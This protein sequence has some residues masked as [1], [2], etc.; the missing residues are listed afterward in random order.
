MAKEDYS[1]FNPTT[2]EAAQAAFQGY[3]P[4]DVSQYQEAAANTQGRT[5][6]TDGTSALEA[7]YMQGYTDA[8][9]QGQY[10]GDKDA[11]LDQGV[12]G[13]SLDILGNAV[14]S[15]GGMVIDAGGFIGSALSGMPEISQ[16]ANK[17][18]E[19]LHELLQSNAAN[20]RKRA[21]AARAISD[22]LY[23]EQLYRKD[24]ANGMDDF[25][26]TLKKV[27]RDAVYWGE[28][29]SSSDLQLFAGSALGSLGGSGIVAKGILKG[30]SKLLGA[31]ASRGKLAQAMAI[32]TPEVGGTY[33]DAASQVM[34]MS[35][36][37]LYNKS[38]E[39]VGIVKE[40]LAKGYDQRTAELMARRDLAN[41]AARSAAVLHTPVAIAAGSLANIG[42]RPAA[43]MFDKAT[44]IAPKSVGSI[45]KSI[46]PAG[47]LGETTEETLQG[48]SSTLAT[49][50]AI[51]N[52]A[53]NTK[54]YTD[55]LGES[56]AESAYGGAISKG[57]ASGVGTINTT[58]QVIKN[59][60][61][62]EE[63]SNTENTTTSNKL[64]DLS[65]VANTT[66]S[67]NTNSTATVTNVDSA[68]N[69]NTTSENIKQEPINQVTQE[70]L[71]KKIN[72]E[73][74][75][76]KEEEHTKDM[77]T[78]PIDGEE[79]SE[80]DISPLDELSNNQNV[81]ST[82]E[83]I[84][85]YLHEINKDDES[86]THYYDAKK[87]FT[88]FNSDE[89][90]PRLVEWKNTKEEIESLQNSNEDK[91]EEIKA[92]TEK[93]NKL[94]SEINNIVNN[95]FNN[96]EAND[97]FATNE[98]LASF[99]MQYPDI[100]KAPKEKREE[101]RNLVKK[102]N[103]QYGKYM[104]NTISN[105]QTD[106]EAVKV[107]RNASD[108]E[109]S[110]YM[111]SMYNIMSSSNTT[112]AQKEAAQTRLQKIIADP[113]AREKFR[114]QLKTEVYKNISAA[115]DIQD[116][117]KKLKA[118]SDS[119]IFA[120]TSTKILLENKSDKA[121]SKGGSGK[122]RY[123]LTA[124]SGRVISS[125]VRGNKKSLEKNLN[126]LLKVVD[127]KIQKHVALENALRNADPNDQLFRSVEP[128]T[129]EESV[130]SV[131]LGNSGILDAN[132]KE[133]LAMIK[134]YN[135]IIDVLS[136][137]GL[138]KFGENDEPRKKITYRP[139][140]FD[141]E[142]INRQMLKIKLARKQRNSD[143][144]LDK[145]DTPLLNENYEVV[146]IMSDKFAGKDNDDVELVATRTDNLN[147]FLNQA[148]EISENEEK[149]I[150][151]K[152]E[153]NKLNKLTEDKPN[154]DIGQIVTDSTKDTLEKI[155]G[156]KKTEP[157]ETPVNLNEETN[158][159]EEDNSNI[160]LGSNNESTKETNLKFD[161]STGDRYTNAGNYGTI[162]YIDSP[163]LDE[164]N[165]PKLDEKGEQ[166][167]FKQKVQLES[168]QELVEHNAK[169]KEEIIKD[170]PNLS[171]ND[172]ESLNAL[173]SIANEQDT[174]LENLHFVAYD[175]KPESNVSDISTYKLLKNYK[176]LTG[177]KTDKD[178]IATENALVKKTK[179]SR[180][181]NDF[182]AIRF[183]NKDTKPSSD[184]ISV[185]ENYNKKDGKK[186][187]NANL[188]S[189]TKVHPE[190]TNYIATTRAKLLGDN[191]LG[192]VFSQRT[193]DTAIEKAINMVFV[194]RGT[195]ESTVKN[196]NGE[197]QTV[198]VKTYQKANVILIN[199]SLKKEDKYALEQL[200]HYTGFK[201]M[202]V[203]KAMVNNLQEGNLSLQEAYDDSFGSANGFY[204]NNSIIP[205]T[206]TEE[207]DLDSFN[208]SLEEQGAKP[209]DN[210]LLLIN[211]DNEPIKTPTSKSISL[212]KLKTKITK[213]TPNAFN[214]LIFPIRNLL[215]R[216]RWDSGI[217]NE[218]EF[219]NKCME[220]FSNDQSLKTLYNKFREAIENNWFNN[221]IKKSIEENKGVGR[222]LNSLFNPETGKLDSSKWSYSNS[223]LVTLLEQN[224]KAEY[225]VNP[226][227]AEALVS[228]ATIVTAEFAL[229]SYNKSDEA[230][231]ED[232]KNR[233]ITEKEF[234]K[235]PEE[236]REALRNGVTTELFI[237]A[238]ASKTKD[239]LGI[240]TNKNVS[241]TNNA[242]DSFKALAF[243]G[244]EFAKENGLLNLTKIKLDE[245][246]D[247]SQ[248]SINWRPNE[249]TK[250]DYISKLTSS[251]EERNIDKRR[252][253]FADE[254][255]PPIPKYKDN[256]IEMS[257]M[258]IDNAK[259]T[260]GVKYHLDEEAYDIFHDL[261]PDG[262]AAFF[263]H[264]FADNDE[265]AKFKAEYT[266][267]SDSFASNSGKSKG[268]ARDLQYLEER[269]E[270]LHNRF[271]NEPD[272]HY[273]RTDMHY[274]ANGRTQEYMPNG[275]QGSK[276]HR[277][278]FS[279]V[280]SELDITNPEDMYTFQKS[281]IQGLG[282]KPAKMSKDV[283][284]SSF[285]KLLSVIKNVELRKLPNETAFEFG[286][287]MYQVLLDMNALVPQVDIS[288]FGRT[289]LALQ[290]MI[291]LKRYQQALENGNKNIKITLPLERDG[292]SD[293]THNGQILLSPLNTAKDFQQLGK[294]GTYIGDENQ[295]K[296]DF[297]K[298]KDNADN[299]ETIARQSSEESK[300]VYNDNIKPTL[301]NKTLDI[302]KEKFF[303]N[304]VR[305]NTEKRF[306]EKLTWNDIA[307]S[308]YLKNTAGT[309]VVEAIN[310]M[311]DLVGNLDTA[312]KLF[313]DGFSITS[314]S[315]SKVNDN[316]EE[317]NNRVSEYGE[318]VDAIINADSDTKN[319]LDTL[320]KTVEE[321]LKNVDKLEKADKP[322][323][324][325]IATAK[326]TASK[327][328]KEL[329]DFTEKT[330]NS[331][332]QDILQEDINF[333]LNGVARIHA[334]LPATASVYGQ[335]MAANS[336]NIVDELQ[337]ER[338]AKKIDNALEKISEKFTNSA[339]EQVIKEVRET[340]DWE[341]ARSKLK[342]TPELQ[343]ELH[344]AL[345]EL[346]VSCID[347]LVFGKDYKKYRAALN[348]VYL[349]GS[350]G[351]NGKDF[352]RYPLGVTQEYLELTPIFD[353][354]NSDIKLKN[355]WG[356]AI[357]NNLDRNQ[358][359]YD[360]S[361]GNYIEVSQEVK[362][363][364]IKGQIEKQNKAIQEAF[365]SKRF[366]NASILDLINF[367]RNYD[368]RETLSGHGKTGYSK[369]SV[370]GITNGIG[371]L[372]GEP[373][374][375]ATQ[376][377]SRNN[378]Q[379][380][381][382][383]LTATYVV[384]GLIHKYAKEKGVTDYSRL[385][386]TGM[387]Q[388]EE[389]ELDNKI[390]T[391]YGVRDT[392]VSTHAETGLFAKTR[393]TTRNGGFGKISNDDD[394]KNIEN[395][396][397][398]TNPLGGTGSTY[399]LTSTYN[400]NA[401]GVQ[402]LSIIQNGDA[403]MQNVI[404]QLAVSNEGLENI[405]EESRNTIRELLKITRNGFDGFDNDIAQ[406]QLISAILNFT[407]LAK[408]H[409][410]SMTESMLS[411]L[412]SLLNNDSGMNLLEE[413]YKSN[414][415]FRYDLLRT[416]STVSIEDNVLIG[417]A[418]EDGSS[419]YKALATPPSFTEL[420][421]AL[422]KMRD[423]V[424]QVNEDIKKR[425]A[426]LLSYPIN[427]SHVSIDEYGYAYNPKEY[428]EANDA[429]KS[430]LT[431][432]LSD[433]DNTADYNV[434]AQELSDDFNLRASCT[435]A[436]GD[437]TYK[438]N[439]ELYLELKL[440]KYG[441]QEVFDP[442]NKDAT[443][444]EKD[445]PKIK[446]LCD[447]LVNAG[448]PERQYL[449]FISNLVDSGILKSLIKGATIGS[450][451]QFFSSLFEKDMRD[452][453]N[454]SFRKFFITDKI[455]APQYLNYK[456]L[457]SEDI[458]NDVKNGAFSWANLLTDK[459]K[460]YISSKYPELSDKCNEIRALL[461]S[462]NSNT[463][464]DSQISTRE[465]HDG[466]IVPSLKLA[467]VIASDPELLNMARDS[468]LR[469]L[470]DIMSKLQSDS[471]SG[472]NNF[473]SAQRKIDYSKAKENDV[474]LSNEVGNATTVE[475][476][477]PKTSSE[478][479]PPVHPFDF[480][481]SLP[482]KNNRT[483]K[484]NL[485]DFKNTPIWNHL[486]VSAT[487]LQRQILNSHLPS[488]LEVVI[489]GT[490]PKDNN[491]FYYDANNEKIVISA[492]AL[493]D[494]I[495]SFISNPE[496]LA[497][498]T[499]I[500][501]HELM[502]A[503]T[504]KLIL[505]AKQAKDKGL[506]TPVTKALDAIND[507]ANN[508]AIDLNS[509]ESIDALLNEIN[510]NK[511]LTA[512]DKKLL[513]ENIKYFV[514][515][516]KT[517]RNK[518]NNGLDG[519]EELVELVA[520]VL[521]N[522][523][524][525]ELL[526]TIEVKVSSSTLDT[527]REYWKQLAQNL[528]DFLALFCSRSFK[529][530]VKTTN[531][532]T[533][534][535][536]MSNSD[537]NKVNL[538]V[539]LS[540]ASHNLISMQEM[541]QEI[542]NS[543]ISSYRLGVDVKSHSNEMKVGDLMQRL[544]DLAKKNP[545]FYYEDKIS[546]SSAGSL[547]HMSELR[548]NN[549]QQDEIK[550][551][552]MQLN[553][554]EDTKSANITSLLTKAYKYPYISNAVV[555][556]K[557]QNLVTSIFKYLT[558]D[559]L[560][561]TDEKEKLSKKEVNLLK[562]SR[563]NFLTNLGSYQVST[564]MALVYT[565]PKFSEMLNSIN[566]DKV[567][568]HIKGLNEVKFSENELDNTIANFTANAL[569]R[570]SDIFSGSAK[571][572]NIG[573]LANSLTNE[574]IREKVDYE[575]LSIPNKLITKTEEGFKS[576]LRK[577]PDAKP[578]RELFNFLSK[579]KNRLAR[580]I[581]AIAKS[582]RSYEA[583]RDNLVEI[584]AKDIPLL[585]SLVNFIVKEL[586]AADKNMANLHALEKQ[587]KAHI[588]GMRTAYRETTPQL[589]KKDFQKAGVTYTPEIGT[590]LTKGV[591][592]LD[593][594]C[595]NNNQIVSTL[596][597]SQKELS[598][599]KLTDVP[600]LNKFKNSFTVANKKNPE[601]LD[602][603]RTNHWNQI[604]SFADDLAYKLATGSF[605]NTSG[606]HFRSAQAILNYFGP[607]RDGKHLE[608]P[609]SLVQGL[610][611][612][613]SIKALSYLEPDTY[614]KLSDLNKTSKKKGAYINPVLYIA[615]AQ[616]DLRNQE[617]TNCKHPLNQIKGYYPK[618]PAN[619]AHTALVSAKEYNNYLALGYIDTGKSYT[620][621]KGKKFH[622]MTNTRNPIGSY[623]Q[624]ALQTVLNKSGGV[625]SYT[626][627][628]HEKVAEYVSKGD[629]N[630]KPKFFVPVNIDSAK[631][632]GNIVFIYN[633][634]TGNPRGYEILSDDSL[635]ENMQYETDA[636]QIIGDWRGRNHE[637]LAAMEMNKAVLE[638]L[639]E[640]YLK[641]RSNST[642][643]N[644]YIN[645]LESK[646]AVIKDALEAFPPEIH[647]MLKDEKL[648]PDGF[649]IRKDL[650]EDVIGYREAS[651]NDLLVGRTDFIN[652]DR[653]KAITSYIIKLVGPSGFSKI[654]KAEDILKSTV[655]L[656]KNTIVL[657]SGVVMVANILANTM[658][659]SM[660]GVP[661]NTMVPDTINITKQL[662]HYNV[663]KKRRIALE[664][665]LSKTD[666][667][668]LTKV[669]QIKKSI[670]A[671]D[672]ALEQAIPDIK[673]LIDAGEY[674]TISDLSD[675]NDDV[676]PK[677]GKFGEWLDEQWKKLP[678]PVRNAGRYA[679]VSQGTA[680]YRF[681]E[682]GTQY[683]DFIGKAIYYKHLIDEMGLTKEEALE[684]VR[685]VFVN[686]DMLAG[687]GRAYL[688]N[689]GLLWFFN[690]KLRIVRSAWTMLVDHPLRFALS[691]VLPF[692]FDLD[693]PL[694][695]NVLSKAL[696]GSL[697]SS[698]GVDTLL[699][700]PSQN[701]WL[702]LTA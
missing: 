694:T 591:L 419:D 697:S 625:D 69:T 574:L 411:V 5:Y 613:I 685:Y 71:D 658:Q 291:H 95:D 81:V 640:M 272:K 151:Q 54:G 362:D 391:E 209:D 4:K 575:K 306:L 555:K 378:I 149:E 278:T 303:N 296:P 519:T 75:S 353:N 30:V 369:T 109:I 618:S 145:V 372:I 56:I 617:K 645:L 116:G 251:I 401:S 13:R 673:E 65:K 364:F 394:G 435:F 214:K 127:A 318:R 544:E 31:A 59:A 484:Y 171:Q 498:A 239:L 681:M 340:G 384:T 349:F 610:D 263:D 547:H 269:H 321:S 655:S 356:N 678:E 466:I 228:A 98:K 264:K 464:P 337:K 253:Y 355:E 584:S 227:V 97:I 693:S 478:F 160:S 336:H 663:Y 70:E 382:N 8:R 638:H 106:E 297:I 36:T 271:P 179:Q 58:G 521:Q 188:E 274:S 446:E 261:G 9:E 381:L 187:K 117:V 313:D 475:D 603:Y 463:S 583:F 91:S 479:V 480:L 295:T 562:K 358:K 223:G 400:I 96:F 83:D 252:V 308:E 39:F 619:E 448:S 696:D 302:L 260:R 129:L 224:N 502:H 471:L 354:F 276:I 185:T 598:S 614:K 650:V 437:G 643:T 169:K 453:S 462:V 392:A 63:N 533:I 413:L 275:P 556:G 688:E 580:Q 183:I 449:K 524:V 523:K 47:I 240:S 467:A 177:N 328:I 476:R 386:G 691:T 156:E 146:D 317:Y 232:L 285:Q 206:K 474:K 218:L 143:A 675:V 666:T 352:G 534:T 298:N 222:V 515:N 53:D 578:L 548:F 312:A 425:N 457:N 25:K 623:N 689:L 319:K 530:L 76:R 511:Y 230:I 280:K 568:A 649:M 119:N 543:D 599:L 21:Q 133:T 615:E 495:N 669:N 184:Y 682:K 677:M 309:I 138:N 259:K 559:N 173:E 219:R 672:A 52:T 288:I 80:L 125:L 6:D 24:V 395:Q 190:I 671:L 140:N 659:L 385:N 327:H 383:L 380:R 402:A 510:S 357:R 648:F 551:K 307:Y 134:V 216:R 154:E 50:T 74:A 55:G 49:N 683:G 2:P 616:R 396:F 229:G 330:I 94:K 552:L 647:K 115:L 33:N 596:K 90:I 316:S 661:L 490:K 573:S 549:K 202:Y 489:D 211:K 62:D 554:L 310:Q 593:L 438:F 412:D 208:T 282:G 491:H 379:E 601:V 315:P 16:T 371:I 509:D 152:E 267:S 545:R 324:V 144:K 167:T 139:E 301:I 493:L 189:L 576:Y 247:M 679:T 397:R 332:V 79:E 351:I 505:A 86:N 433:I 432:Q 92:L 105:A 633:R 441:L 668:N 698:M 43:T 564:V 12:V 702:N 565:S 535:S 334:K 416:L 287:R 439:Q 406:A 405:P 398:T 360:A 111:L 586:L 588:Q 158:E 204:R 572:R 605:K 499:N 344:K 93:S 526:N 210:N 331:V 507:I 376:T 333:N 426:V 452:E 102:S 403:F 268:Y 305:K 27:G 604:Q 387:S 51:K 194:A 192:T 286:K 546:K 41:S 699:R 652:P 110:K 561:T 670:K 155:S 415:D 455:F 359:T 399:A 506:S 407:D 560:I 234:Y 103:E 541:N 57:I 265:E 270:E 458:R 417:G 622:Y 130:G 363:N 311:N 459:M 558:P 422:H 142:F 294:T 639:S 641:D 118:N 542:E 82:H 595:L 299:Y 221:A 609:E 428:Q 582:L 3:L 408:L 172:L 444:T 10:Y 14:S 121:I 628:T 180:A 492:Y 220:V 646:S 686:Y 343:T 488:N 429:F 200:T 136:K 225:V 553:L 516:L 338:I 181:A 191:V 388:L 469:L 594:G 193:V 570:V 243:L 61:V 126:H 241:V 531:A 465:I 15:A 636:S 684:K 150:N 120:N 246:R 284:D 389:R 60:F 78:Q 128:N 20:R 350:N 445:L 592:N 40:N 323:K 566:F 600:I 35:V 42:I 199:N 440:G 527:I 620:N 540:I 198:K 569:D 85:K 45:S 665:Q 99:R 345:G 258:E 460:T 290:T 67:N 157:T 325:A 550:S 34:S 456:S 585:S 244:L 250:L 348:T 168:H 537:S 390:K 447:K 423:R 431:K 1:R 153:A 361:L 207:F 630:N 215:M 451:V 627:R 486:M 72:E 17:F 201:I 483:L 420:V 135:Y 635:Y 637:Q 667:N 500:L 104:N 536:L 114:G 539:A 159:I 608:I 186:I 404:S 567:S 203:D 44:N 38:P 176:K 518:V 629:K 508:A 430:N 496:K 101:Y 597:K 197:E 522:N 504:K 626:G 520:I 46:D 148:R 373:I 368:I 279:N 205:T 29:Q 182:G 503:A 473:I 178:S 132:K 237:K 674:S 529:N 651:V 528:K 66:S 257:Q 304:S 175:G 621:K 577:I 434:Y 314:Q 131:F 632:E 680:L 624:G 660:L 77:F 289:A 236:Q 676:V 231:L 695:D 442:K 277:A 454:D 607:V 283:L 538:G 472:S 346:G 164:D 421:D 226:I 365:T 700:A 477:N 322:N 482:V 174:A 248:I 339:L 436:Q 512:I 22:N 100:T 487:P 631:Q 161:N 367:L 26:A 195:D 612:Y 514:S 335:G 19:G 644:G 341:T 233:G 424:N 87:G 450:R 611:E 293:G 292:S 501:T 525:P 165:K 494:N 410:S 393:M 657:R 443:L 107:A 532:D 581:P 147:E 468:K 73:N 245:N 170:N 37:D 89:L 112:D 48:I 137:A 656:A 212:S 470:F 213:D 375:R 281:V 513:S 606:A 162:V 273:L 113:E 692:N 654:A 238:L 23:S 589:I 242:D 235:L 196:E 427:F 11:P 329:I 266:M 485:Q 64:P 84:N 262:C 326:E 254:E 664:F 377:V 634:N 124:L 687:R 374:Y 342:D 18:S 347:E 497:L 587:T 217:K 557:A 409:N 68:V 481:L 256:G 88:T 461:D 122:G 370:Y 123:S 249:T 602:Y 28:R 690:Y 563:Y 300:E 32:A 653:A 571:I 255:M 141:K 320:I 579:R 163:V 166:V 108:S 418:R 590:I 642:K 517:Y 7:M 662:E 701:V 414:S 366:E